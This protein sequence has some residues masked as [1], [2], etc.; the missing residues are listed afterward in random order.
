MSQKQRG[1]STW[2]AR[3]LDDANNRLRR[4]LKKGYEDVYD[5]FLREDTFAQSLASEGSTDRDA[6]YFDLLASLLLPRPDRTSAQRSLM[7]SGIMELTADQRKDVAKIAYIRGGH[8]NMHPMFQGG[9]EENFLILYRRRFMSLRQFTILV[10]NSRHQIL[11]QT[12]LPSATNEGNIHQVDIVR[13]AHEDSYQII[14]EEVQR[15]MKLSILLS[16]PIAKERKPHNMVNSR[17][18]GERFNTLPPNSARAGGN[19]QPEIVAELI[20]QQQ[21]FQENTR[22]STPQAPLIGPAVRAMLPKSSRQVWV[23]K[24]DPALSDEVQE[25]GE[26]NPVPPDTRRRSEWTPSITLR[27]APWHRARHDTEAAATAPLAPEPSATS[28]VIRL[29]PREPPYPPPSSRM[30][31]Q[32]KGGASAAR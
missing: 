27:E 5:R 12:F 28:S 29:R 20:Q 24:T 13:G 31:G 15:K 10:A 18:I 3:T 19:L 16:E 17:P 4:S 26:S 32:S 1:A 30:K 22:Q 23:R 21:V 9:V 11:I 25:T 6:A 7:Q 8:G 14:K 2:E